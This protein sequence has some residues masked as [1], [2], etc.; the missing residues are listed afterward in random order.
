MKPDYDQHSGDK[1]AQIK[2]LLSNAWKKSGRG[3]ILSLAFIFLSLLLLLFASITAA[4][5]AYFLPSAWKI[6]GLLTGL[7][8]SI[9]ITYLFSRQISDSS[10][11]VF[12]K[13]YLKTRPKDGENIQS[14][15][16]LYEDQNRDQSLFYEAALESNLEKVKPDELN[17]DLKSY[18]GRHHTIKSATRSFGA[19]LLALVVFSLTIFQNP[20]GFERTMTFWQTFEQPNPYQYAI[21]PGDTTI[22]QGQSIQPTIEFSG[23]RLPETVTF[24]YKTD[25][26]ENYRERPMQLSEGTRFQPR[27][28]EISSSV[29]YHVVMDGFRSESYRLS[30]QVQP[31]FDDLIARITPPSYTNLPESEHEYPFSALRF[32]PG[33]EIHFEGEL[34]KEV[35]QIELLS[36]GEP[37]EMT[38]TES[39]SRLT[40]FATI[41]PET[42]DTLTFQMT[43]HDGLS[44]RNPFRTILRMTEDE[45][46]VVVIREPTGVVMENEPRDLDILYQ[47][48]DDFGI[49]RAELQ[50][51]IYRS[52]VD[53]PQ[54]GAQQLSTPEN[55]RNTRISW[56]LTELELRPRDE[57]RFRI[58]ALDNDAVSGGKWGESQEVVIRRPSMAEFFEEIDSKE[59][60]VQGELDQVSDEFE[61]MEQEYERFLERLRQNPE[62]GF[63]EQEMLESVSEQQQRIDETVEQL[64]EQYEELRRE[65]EESSSISDETRE[66]YREL[67]QLMEELDDPDLQN[68]LRELR[69]AMENMNPNQIEQALENVSFN[70][71]L[72]KE[73]LERT[74][75]LFKQL[76]MNSDLDKLAQQYQDLSERMREQPEATLEQLKSEMETARDDMDS[77]SDQLERLDDNP[78]RRSE[79]K[80]KELKEQAQERLQEIQEQMEQLGQEMDGKMEDGE[81]SPDSQMQQQQQQISEQLQQEADNMRE[82]RQEM[83]GQQLQVNILGLQWALYTLLELSETQE[84]LT[85]DSQET[86]NR[87][88]GFVNLA[89]QQ[90]YV[91]GQFSA[92]ADTIF[93]ISSEIPGVPNRINRK[94]AEVE[95]TLQRAVD[96][97]SER[98]Q[99][100]AMIT[101][102]ES[103]GGINDLSSTIASLIEQLM[104]QDGDGGGGGGMSMQQM[105][106]QMQQ[107]SG[108][109]EQ[110]N[111]QLQEMV[112]DMQGD[113][114]SRE[115]SER[116]DEMA[117]QQNEIRRQL[118]ELQ[119]SGALREGDQALSELQRMIDEME[120]SINDM[121]GG[122]TDRMM[123]E[124]QQN[125][126]SRMLS[127]EEAMERRGE[128]EEREG[129]LA[130]PFDSELPPDLTLEELQQEIRSRLQD[131]NYTRFSEEHQRLIERY[132]EML[133]RMDDAAI[134]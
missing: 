66:S 1:A 96:E 39:D 29:S 103:L 112:N 130:E 2:E 80:L 58:R 30:V 85:K 68:A 125:I 35:D 105:I 94:K 65:M 37:L 107:M 99:R 81:T 40:Y 55:G 10:F 82:M 127:A 106:E 129:Q 79:E 38:L 43:D 93:Q 51:S 78:P 54:H 13:R 77:L 73:R 56:D 60:S 59:R 15:I 14:A 91:R 132:F 88:A 119:R 61:Q 95:R 36:S 115:Q 83:G 67:Q 28:F 53:E 62:G 57:V 41:T 128:E 131:P 5:S 49:E 64:K 123:I 111:Q 9:A 100:S 52:Y 133:R 70:E 33:S 46:P 17:R 24:L 11:D 3:R 22:E 18:L 50:W 71:E 47:A 122:V 90:N 118:R 75:E 120:D 72:Y 6:G 8:L 20:D 84:F 89:R 102:R 63:E 116:L 74:K 110:L 12:V 108:D 98:N 113:R 44:N 109:Q 26:E 32:Y 4:E 48:T 76:K 121:R 117:R 124:R 27:E 104:D 34:N 86:A 23:D 31:R 69:E 87:S 7:A 114:L 101:S 16:D 25:V 126:L 134:Q 45:P 19:L 97:M 42:T 92:V 21:S